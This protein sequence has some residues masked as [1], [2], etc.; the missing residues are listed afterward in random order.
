[1]GGG[2]GKLDHTVQL[3]LLGLDSAGKTS[4]LYHLKFDKF[5]CTV[6][7]VGF[8]CEKIKAKSGK[9]KG[10][11]FTI[12][13]IGGQDK[14][15]PLWKSYLRSA[16]GMVFVVDSVDT[17]RMEEA[18]ME[19]LKLV[20]SPDY[21]GLPLLVVANKQDLPRASSPEEIEKMLTLSDLSPGQLYH[22]QPACA[23]TG[24]GL[25]ECVDIMYDLIIKRRKTKSSKKKIK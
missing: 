8:N 14:T 22:I 10:T 3:V 7:T 17:E 2:L 18:R 23:I 5:S 16:D 24:E 11:N 21:G 12:W 1:M 4:V 15:R 13:D 20:K 19:L 6:P 25:P 9:A